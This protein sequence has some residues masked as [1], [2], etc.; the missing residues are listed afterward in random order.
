MICLE[1]YTTEKDLRLLSFLHI[2]ELKL[3]NFVLY[4]FHWWYM[5]I[6]IVYNVIVSFISSQSQ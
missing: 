6:I 2:S 1:N 4:N 5:L 3:S